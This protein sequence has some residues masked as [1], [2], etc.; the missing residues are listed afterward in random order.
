MFPSEERSVIS[1]VLS[2]CHGDANRAAA[3]LA[4]CT[5]EGNCDVHSNMYNI[6]EQ[7]VQSIQCI[8]LT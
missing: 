6:K 1:D 2:S 4:G 3:K 8:H 5:D 7:V